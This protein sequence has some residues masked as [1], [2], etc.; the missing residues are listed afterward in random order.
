MSIV[1]GELELVL[2]DRRLRV[3]VAGFLVIVHI[4]VWKETIELRKIRSVN[5]DVR[6]SRK[7]LLGFDDGQ[8]VVG[9]DRFPFRQEPSQR[10]VDQVKAFVFGRMQEFEILLDSGCFGGATE[11]LVVCHAESRR[12]VHVIHVLIV[13]ERPR[14]AYQRIDHM[15]KIDRLLAAAEQPRHTLETF[16]PIQS[17][18]WSW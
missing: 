2:V 13:E 1:G 18:R 16:V 7:L 10:V 14:L 12:G 15:A 9:S 11:Q 4:L 8:H 5:V 3:N 6:R 17:S